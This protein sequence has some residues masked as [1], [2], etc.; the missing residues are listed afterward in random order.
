MIPR[1]LGV[2]RVATG[3][4]AAA[5]LLLTGNLARVGLIAMIRLCGIH[6]GYQL[7]I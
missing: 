4:A 2:R 7:G 1:R 6:A 3:L 5:A